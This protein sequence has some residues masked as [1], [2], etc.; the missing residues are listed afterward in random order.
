MKLDGVCPR[1]GAKELRI[2]EYTDRRARWGL[3]MKTTAISRMAR[4]L[5]AGGFGLVLFLQP[6][7]ARAEERPQNARTE[8]WLSVSATLILGG[9]AGSYALRSAALD[10]RIALLLTGEPERYRL[11]EDALAARRFAW[12]FGAGASLMAVTTLLVLLYQPALDD[13]SHETTP[14]VNPVLSAN[15]IGLDCR[16]RF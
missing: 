13:K 16:G 2:P 12:G 1:A 8:L 5:L 10:D 15:Q 14:V 6:L 7:A 11:E 3:R 4:R 9:I